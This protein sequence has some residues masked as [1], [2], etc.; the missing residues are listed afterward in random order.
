MRSRGRAKRDFFKFKNRLSKSSSAH[1]MSGDRRST[2]SDAYSEA[3]SLAPSEP[4]PESKSEKRKSKLEKV[5]NGLRNFLTELR[6]MSSDRLRSASQNR[7]NYIPIYTHLFT[8][9]RITFRPLDRNSIRLL[10]I[11]CIS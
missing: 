6:S 3:V 5:N 8:I 11:L 10:K 9:F 7:G 2:V 1:S 4:I